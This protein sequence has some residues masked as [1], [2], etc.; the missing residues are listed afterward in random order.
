MTL[1]VLGADGYLGWPLAMRFAMKYD[2]PVVGVDNFSRRRR[3]W[4]MNSDS[5]TPIQDMAVRTAVFKQITG[6]EIQFEY[7]DMRDYEFVENLIKKY[8]PRAIV[9]FAEQ[10]SA[11][12]SMVDARHA[13]ETH[14]NNVNGTLNLLFVL[15]KFAPDCH[16]IKLGTMGEYGTP[17]IDIP[18]GFFEIEY[19]GRKATLPFPRQAGSFYHQTKVHDSNNIMLACKIWGIAS[20]DVMQGVVYGTRT[21]E[22]ALDPRL[23]TR[24][25]VDESFGTAVNRFCAQ[26]I[27]GMPLTPYGKGGQTRGYLNIMDTM[28]CITTL[29]DSPPQK[30]EYRVVNQLTEVFSVLQIAQKIKEIGDR[31]NLNVKI[32]AIPNPRVEAEEHY[33][34]VDYKKL[35]D[36]GFTPIKTMDES[37]QYM[38][39]D[40]LP[41][42]QRVSEHREQIMP[43]I[44]WKEGLLK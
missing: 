27:I 19:R 42:K 39:L 34:N 26:A 32:E 28:R 14:E 5:I 31:L 23:V 9:H 18:E 37:I 24:F 13:V 43:K 38:L 1:M 20:T 33:Y 30:G 25:D 35:K 44:T 3:V 41:N 15:K 36:L 17:G 40:L 21:E 8:K 10:P 7:G 16:L 4:E 12:Y 2:E 22:T 6:R 29:V 11:P